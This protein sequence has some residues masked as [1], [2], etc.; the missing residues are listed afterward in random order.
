M[1]PKKSI[2]FVAV[3]GAVLLFGACSEEAGPSGPVSAPD[4]VTVTNEGTAADQKLSKWLSLHQRDVPLHPEWSNPR[5]ID[6]ECCENI[7]EATE[8]WIEDAENDGVTCIS[9][10]GCP[11]GDCNETAGLCVCDPD[12]VTP[13]CNEGVCTEAGLCG[14]SWCNGYLICDCWGGCKT[15]NEGVAPETLCDDL[16]DLGCCEGTYPI[17]PET[18]DDPVGSGYCSDDPECGAGC[19]TND[20][21]DNGLYCDGA[22]VCDDGDCMPGSDP[23]ASGDECN[24]TCNETTDT[25]FSAYGT[26]CGDPTDTACD[27]P[28]FCD[29]AG[30]CLDDLEPDGTSC[31]DDVF[32]DGIDTCDGAGNCESDGDPCPPITADPEDEVCQA[33]NESLNVCL[34]AAG[35]G[36][37]DGNLCT[38]TDQCNAIGECVGTNPVVCTSDQCYARACNTSTGLCDQTNFAAGTLCY[39]TDPCDIDTC[40]GAGNC[41]D[42][43][44][45]PCDDTNGCTA[46]ACQACVPGPGCNSYEGSGWQCGYNA[47]AM[48]GTACIDGNDCT[49]GDVC[50]GGS[51]AS[52]AA[53][54]CAAFDTSTTDCVTSACVS[55]GDGTPAC[56]LSN[57]AS[58]TSCQD[59]DGCTQPDLCNATGGCVPGAAVTCTDSNTNDCLIP[60]CVEDSL[61]T[62]YTCPNHNAASGSTCNDNNGCTTDLCNSSGVCVSTS[63]ACDPADLCEDMTCTSTGATT[64]TCNYID[65][66]TCCTNDGECTT[67]CGAASTQC[68]DP[69]CTATTG[70]GVCACEI[71]SYI[72]DACTDFD[73]YA[74]P[75]D[76]YD[77]SCNS[78]GNCIPYEVASSS[79]HDRCRDLFTPGP[80]AAL[81]GSFLNIGGPTSLSVQGSTTCM[82]NNYRATGPDCVSPSL[83]YLGQNGKDAVYAFSYQT[84][85]AGDFKLWSYN[86]KVWTS[87]NANVYVT[88][89]I[90]SISDCPEGATGT[91]VYPV[92]VASERC[93]KGY[94]TATEVSEDLCHDDGN[95]SLGQGGCYPFLQTG[96]SANYKCGGSNCNGT[97]WSPGVN[98]NGCGYHW[99]RRYYPAGC[100]NYQ[101]GENC[102]PGTDTTPPYCTGQWGYPADPYNCDLYNPEFTYSKVASHVIFPDGSVAPG[103]TKT[104][105]IFIDGDSAAAQ[106]VFD[107][108]VERNSWTSSPCDRSDDDARVFDVTNVNAAGSVWK[109]S[110]EDVVNS[111]QVVIGGCGSHTC[112]AANST[113]CGGTNC[114]TQC[115]HGWSSSHNPALP[116][117]V[118]CA[119]WPNT[120]TNEFW[121][122]E[123]FFKIH[124]DGSSGT[125]CI[126]LFEDEDRNLT[127]DANRADLVLSFLQRATG[128]GICS[129]ST[130]T[131]L[132]RW[133]DSHDRNTMAT[134]SVNSN[135][136][137]VLEISNRDRLTAPC[138]PA[139][140]S[141]YY[142][143]RARMGNCGYE[144][145][146][147]YYSIYSATGSTTLATGAA[148]TG[149]D[150]QDWYAYNDEQWE[151]GNSTTSA[152]T[153]NAVFTA[154]TNMNGYICYHDSSRTQ[155]GCL[156]V[157]AG[158]TG[159]YS[160]IPIPAGGMVYLIALKYSGTGTGYNLSINW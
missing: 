146:A 9:D 19:V 110:M 152:R 113:R 5:T 15:A 137:H 124:R 153:I 90:N 121:P 147:G 85:A 117:M 66:P 112:D 3:A 150:D 142:K 31:D 49:V 134:V 109:G 78:S 107:I 151:I 6:D 33:C 118:T 104:V 12:L 1:H 69:Y 42:G 144:F 95:E 45:R 82:V 108:S 46:D 92:N 53:Y 145:P 51:C 17:Q 125:Y 119:T 32:C 65:D 105:F 50:S 157:S 114:S 77:G 68:S 36:C 56:P 59:S 126:M 52:G 87:F 41:A 37:N 23:C 100:C 141:C 131:L 97:T 43:A 4:G 102:A 98:P 35:T 67:A 138:N 7:G 96:D 28:D 75:D 139:T 38:Q 160:G 123:E 48:N 21:C 154:G 148:L 71:A 94:S 159:T 62:G 81:F 25:C 91:P 129:N 132:N 120:T 8:C 10:S 80:S 55:D 93:M 29:G 136:P 158:T 2:I 89:N 103:S 47:A 149:A 73:M 76:C 133:W 70:E 79:T 128:T 106:G 115:W 88:Q 39:D 140:Q 116:G 30:N 63:D 20:D 155:I 54:S 58:G 72:G 111:R 44:P 101:N 156:Y 11:S 57:L 135:I 34:S 40:D 74:Y 86:I 18:E 83:A 14:P 13:Q 99:V 26:D 16:A 127:N 84:P 130:W 24:N 122:N 27:N 22:E 64:Y 143:L 61:G 60:G